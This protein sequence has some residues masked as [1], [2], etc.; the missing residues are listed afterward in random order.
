MGHEGRPV[1]RL[2]GA[3]RRQPLD[4]KTALGN[5]AETCRRCSPSTAHSS[6]A[7]KVLCEHLRTGYHQAFI[8]SKFVWVY[9][10]SLSPCFTF[11]SPLGTIIDLQ[12]QTPFLEEA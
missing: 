9:A 3:T 11:L 6:S 7:E 10:L 4:R 12:Q 8:C 5:D 1:E 2:L